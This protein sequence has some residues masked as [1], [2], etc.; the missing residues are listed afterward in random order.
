MRGIGLFAR[1]LHRR[2]TRRRDSLTLFLG[3]IAPVSGVPRAS[4]DKFSPLLRVSA[5]PVP[6]PH[7]SLWLYHPFMFIFA[8][9]EISP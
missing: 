1:L 2:A 6:Q 5:V 8:V 9:Q 3:T 7:A 4:K